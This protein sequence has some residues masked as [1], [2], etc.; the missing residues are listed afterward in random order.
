MIADGR[1]VSRFELSNECECAHA[2]RALTTEA[3]VG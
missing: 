1:E 3:D 2:K